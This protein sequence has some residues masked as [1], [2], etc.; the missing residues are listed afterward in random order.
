MNEMSV[1]S[2][3]VDIITNDGVIDA[4]LFH[5]EGEWPGVVMLTDI[6]GT[7]PA[8]EE[9]ARRLAEHGYVVLLP[10]VYYRG[11]RAPVVDP[12]LPA[13]DPVA[14]AQRNTLRS[15]LTPAAVRADLAALFA[16][17]ENSEFVRGEK[18]GVVGYCMTGGSAMRAAADFPNVVAAAA[19]FH[20]G[21]LAS[22][23]PDSPH[24][25]AGE[26]KGRLYF[27]HADED[28]SMPAEAIARLEETLRNNGVRFRSE[29]YAGARHGFAVPDGAAF[30]PTAAERHWGNL[31]ELLDE[32]LGE[33]G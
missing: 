10:N 28:A 11:G 15:A 27:G 30:N 31:L 17:L 14:R 20:G 22:D 4:L 3:S 23:E 16:Y 13:T 9:M 8:F 5:P 12:T 6:R 18:I 1:L 19:S 32:E 29:T 33:T 26:I 25:R 2:E 21:G 24:L 7:R